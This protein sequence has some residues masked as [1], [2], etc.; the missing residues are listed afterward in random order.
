M[1]FALKR[2]LVGPKNFDLSNWWPP[3]VWS[4]G[5]S[6]QGVRSIWRVSMFFG[7]LCMRTARRLK[8]GLHNSFGL[9]SEA[10][11]F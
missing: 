7:S 1:R 10:L 4:P 8:A 11:P 2:R 3:Q 5:F 9:Q 6:R